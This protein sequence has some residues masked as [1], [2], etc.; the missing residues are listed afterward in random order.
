MMLMFVAGLVDAASL[1]GMGHIFMANVMGNV[2]FM[3]LA[4]SGVPQLSFLRSAAAL[5]AA[6]V[7]SCIASYLDTHLFWRRRNE[8]LAFVVGLAAVLLTLSAIASQSSIQQQLGHEW[9]I[10]VVIL[11]AGTSMGIRNGTMRRLA[12]QGLTT[13]NVSGTAPTESLNL[14]WPRKIT[15][16]IFMFSGAVCG[17]LLLRF[18][19][20]AVF[21][22]GAAISAVCMVLQLVREETDREAKLRRSTL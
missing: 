3:A 8:W 17:S 10:W 2:V 13:T 20:C 14:Y 6:S 4:A 1:L 9:T 16:I 18:S 21:A 22:S 11:C 19:L 5:A 15:S 7:G 12:A